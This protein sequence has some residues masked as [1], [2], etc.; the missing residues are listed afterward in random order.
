MKSTTSNKE[1]IAELRRIARR[2]RGVLRPEEVVE[3]ARARNSILHSKFTWDDTKAAHA[4]RL[5]QAR[6][7]IKTVVEY[8]VVNG[9]KMEV[10]LFQSIGT[11][12]VRGYRET[13]V[14]LSRKPWRD[15]LLRDALG[16]LQRFE[17]RYQHLRELA[18]VFKVTRKI[19]KRIEY[20]KAA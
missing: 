3:S 13:A 5:W 17:T 7:F 14:V 1:V 19:T 8:Q 2:H 11:A 15:Q 16:D 6:Q 10:S 9:E 18:E 12:N 20:R 4:H